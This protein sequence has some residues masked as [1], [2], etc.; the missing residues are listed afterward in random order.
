MEAL[1]YAGGKGTRMGVCGVE[2]PMQIVGG[3]PTVSRVVDALRGAEGIDGILVSVSDNT[4]MTQ[5]F[6]KDQGV[7]TVMTSGESFMDDMHDAFS[8]M[9]GKY[10]FTSPSDLPLLTSRR[11][12]MILDVFDWKMESLI[13]LVDGDTVSSVGITPSYDRELLGRNWVISGLSIMDR[14]KTLRGDYLEEHF[15]YTD[16]LELAVNVNTQKEL[17][18]ARN[19]ADKHQANR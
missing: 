19:L 8:V 1:V 16:F 13:V 9:N 12:E 18:I 15:Q 17:E 11:V 14:E 10:V 4:P 2:K 5:A 3:K 7:E 6:L